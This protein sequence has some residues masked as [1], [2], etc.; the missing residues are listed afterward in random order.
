MNFMDFEIGDNN[1]FDLLNIHPQNFNHG[2]GYLFPAGEYWLGDP[3]LFLDKKLYVSLLDVQFT[4]DADFCAGYYED[5]MIA[6]MRTAYGDGIYHD[7]ENNI[8]QVDS[9]LI[10][11]IPRSLRSDFSSAQ[12]GRFVNLKES[13]IF[14][15][16][17]AGT[18]NLGLDG[19]YIT[20]HTRT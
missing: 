15:K 9:G 7:N 12:Q 8:Y 11:L 4:N 3:A 19:R 10:G 6:A 18:F 17:N 13:T 14:V 20:I 16:D 1:M 2:T 5:Q